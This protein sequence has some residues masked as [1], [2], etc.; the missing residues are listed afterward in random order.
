MITCL[1]TPRNLEYF[2]G[3]IPNE[4]L[5]RWAQDSAVPEDSSKNYMNARTTRLLLILAVDISNLP[6]RKL[7]FRKASGLGNTA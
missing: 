6:V 7:G 4:N 2:A 1:R 3:S 5:W